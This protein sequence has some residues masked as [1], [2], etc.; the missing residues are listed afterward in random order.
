M[1][2]NNKKTDS[3]N[4]VLFFVKYPEPG[5]VKTRLANQL[6][7]E[8]ASCLYASFVLDILCPL[9]ALNANFKIC[10]SPPDAEEKFR[11]WLGSDYSL[12]PQSGVDLGERM[13]NAFVDA[14]A[15]GANKA[16][17]IGSDTPDLPT[18]FLEV[19]IS[20]LTTYDVTLGP[21][22]DGGYY[23]IGFNKNTF[24]P[25]VFEDV[26]WSTNVVLQKTLDKLADIGRG[27][28]LLP[29]WCDIDTAADL[30]SLM[31]RNRETSFNDSL[32]CR[33]V[34]EKQEILQNAGGQV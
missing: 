28:Y 3:K 8:L 31:V 11:Q 5:Q 32:T 24:E 29:E 23:L 34:R 6:G 16:I 27:V 26:E 33:F 10:Y 7:N 21:S 25:S 2:K 13:K 18:D 12:V 19:A 30:N 14:F 15:G 17:L 9:N 20:A 1:N 22:Y 4:C